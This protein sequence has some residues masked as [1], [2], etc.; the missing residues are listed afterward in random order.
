[1]ALATMQSPFA[2]PG[3]PAPGTFDPTKIA[4]QMQT[5][6]NVRTM[7]AQFFGD[8][9]SRQFVQDSGNVTN[10]LARPDNPWTPGTPMVATPSESSPGASF[11]SASGPSAETSAMPGASL[12]SRTPGAPA[13]ITPGA[14]ASGAPQPFSTAQEFFK[15]HPE[16]E[17]VMPARPVAPMDNVHGARKALMLAFLGLNKFG[18]GLDHQQSSYA[19][20][21]LGR[22]LNATQAQATY[23]NSQPQLK[24]QAEDARFSQILGNTEKAAQIA[25]TGAQTGLITAQTGSYIGPVQQAG[26][27]VYQDLLGHWQNRDVPDFPS[28]A[29]AILGGQPTAVAQYVQSKLSSIYQVPQTGK[30]YTV[31]M[32]DD[33]PKSISM[34]G[35]TYPAVVGKDG[36]L[37]APVDPSIPPQAIQDFNAAEAAHQQ[38][39]QEGQTVANNAADRQGAA[40]GRGFTQAATMQ[41]NAA[42]LAKE[43]ERRKGMIGP[44]G[45]LSAAQNNQQLIDQ[46][47]SAKDH[48]SRSAL[49]DQLAQALAPAGSK[50]LAPAAID[51]LMDSGSVSEQAGQKLK[52]WLSGAGPLPDETVP[53]WV[54]AAKVLNNVK[55]QNAKDA[56]QKNDQTWDNKYAASGPKWSAQTG[57]PGGGLQ[58]GQTVNVKGRTMKVTA[59]HPDGSFDAQ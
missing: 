17:P 54:N 56:L 51:Q 33:A 18:A 38:K 26:E 57:P 50:R 42:E 29:K 41:E 52:K 34:Y 40:Q 20:E 28:Y 30:G 22:Q 15:A 46:L 12:A 2:T 36:R 59:V 10:A 31:D 5:D 7:F 19:D 44:S 13:A 11:S 25:Q 32:Q 48:A 14:Q 58:V 16:E 24:Q 21:F 6:P 3:A 27:K 49:V 8:P 43:T 39:F 55:V 47:G 9:A 37:S 53:D 35:K 45:D 1:M 23:D 4:Q